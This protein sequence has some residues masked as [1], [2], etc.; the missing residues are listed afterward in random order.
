MGGARKVNRGNHIIGA[1]GTTQF[2]CMPFIVSPS[3]VQ[4]RWRDRCLPFVSIKAS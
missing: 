1:C 4:Q 2:S 3:T